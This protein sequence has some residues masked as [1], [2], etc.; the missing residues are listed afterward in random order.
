MQIDSRTR[1]A[2]DA[3]IITGMDRAVRAFN[4]SGYVAIVKIFSFRLSNLVDQRALVVH[5][6]LRLRQIEQWYNWAPA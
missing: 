1:L 6:L 3:A 5:E 4:R 2:Q